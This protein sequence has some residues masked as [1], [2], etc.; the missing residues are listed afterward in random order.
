MSTFLHLVCMDHDPPL[1]ADSESGQH[2]S[3]LPQIRADLAAPLAELAAQAEAVP[4]TPAFEVDPWY[5][6]RHTLWFRR[7]HP[8][9]HIGIR[10]EYGSEHPTTEPAPRRGGG[11]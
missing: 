3:D 10:D 4:G 8:T 2:L 5:F 7:D 1:A 6:R 9:C 11:L